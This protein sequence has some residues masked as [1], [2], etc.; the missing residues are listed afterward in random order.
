M[1]LG[2]LSLGLAGIGVILPVIPTKPLVILAA[3]CFSRGAPRLGIW[4]E[5][6]RLWGPVLT[7]WH[8][9]GAIAPRYKAL[10]VTMMGAVFLY[11]FVTGVP[12]WVL[13]LQAVLI[14][15]GAAFVLTRPNGA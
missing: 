12:T 7:D 13:A 4:L 8:E 3:I 10:A 1:L 5:N 6:S 2:F 11:S 14:G 15:A 9:N